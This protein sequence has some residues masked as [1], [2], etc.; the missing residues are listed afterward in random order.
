MPIS[1][2]DLIYCEDG[3]IYHLGL[4][5]EQV[6][7]L[8][9]TVGDPERVPLVSQYFDSVETKVTHREFVSHIGRVGDCS[10][11]VISSGMG[12]DNVEILMT[13]LDALVNIDREA[14]QTKASLRSLTIIRLGTSGALQPN[15]PLDS[16]LISQTAF[17]LDTLMQFYSYRMPSSF[18]KAVDQ[19]KSD[20]DLEFTP[21]AAEADSE[22]ITLFQSQF[23]VGNTVTCPGFYAPQGRQ[24]R[25]ASR[26]SRFLEKLINFR[27]SDI[28][29]ANLEME[30]AGYYALGQLLGHRVLSV[31]AILAHRNSGKFSTNPAKT[32]GRMIERVLAKTNQL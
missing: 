31:N 9:F 12:T 26:Q 14:R 15:V 13:E 18:K 29:L 16:I 3:S 8:I 7:D 21:Y 24:L 27:S 25:L 32:V 17:G 30:T 5:S 19:L 10:L 28:T 1:E 2:T 20:L 11:M 4:H 22:L 6:P 23:Q